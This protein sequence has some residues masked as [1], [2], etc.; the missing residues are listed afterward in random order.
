MRSLP[1]VASRF[2][3]STIVVVGCASGLAGCAARQ[4]PAAS[5]A[6]TVPT[7]F[8]ADGNSRTADTVF[9]LGAESPAS[10]G[11]SAA[12][13]RGTNCADGPRASRVS[14]PVVVSLDA[15]HGVDWRDFLDATSAPSLGHRPD[16]LVSRDPDVI[17]FAMKRADYFTQVLPWSTTYVVV[18]ARAPG[19]SAIPARVERGALARDAV[20]GEARGAEE[21]FSWL[22]DARCASPVRAAR[23]APA[24]V[25]AFAS[26][27]A[28]ARQLAERLVS[29]AG[30]AN[31]PAWLT[32]ALGEHGAHATTRV[33]A[34]PADS[35]AD[36]L[37]HGRAAVAILA[38]A[39][40]PRTSCGTRANAPVPAGAIPLVDSRAHA[41]VR[42]GSG[43]AFLVAPNGTL[44][45]IR[46]RR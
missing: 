26:G 44:H 17:A 40:D 38:V 21:P 8:V 20:K 9:A 1:R 13:A 37:S 30:G 11:E 31:R 5:A 42:R 43:V 28:T 41:I 19:S 27:D 33:V 14:A 32:A 29:L 3:P 12:I 39:R 6:W 35:I 2:I 25:V 18:A 45:F 15:P 36:A 24:P 7:C 46:Q 10:Y 16:V 23:S 34:V 4:G 22:I